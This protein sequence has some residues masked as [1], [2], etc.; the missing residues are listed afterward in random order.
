MT[1]LVI[2]IS[3]LRKLELLIRLTPNRV[4]FNLFAHSTKLLLLPSGGK[5]DL[6]K[7]SQD[8][9]DAWEL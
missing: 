5:T 9:L 4:S 2:S 8:S 1:N 3:P 6:H 7:L